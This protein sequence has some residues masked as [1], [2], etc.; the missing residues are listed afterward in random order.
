MFI[1]NMVEKSRS[2]LMSKHNQIIALRKKAKDTSLSKNERDVS[3]LMAEKLTAKYG[4]PKPN[5]DPK[6]K[7][8]KDNRPNYGRIDDDLPEGE[9]YK[10]DVPALSMY[11]PE[12][13]KLKRIFLAWDNTEYRTINGVICFQTKNKE[14]AKT[15]AIILRS[16]A[17]DVKHTRDKEEKRK[18]TVWY[19]T[20]KLFGLK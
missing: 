2:G 17:N 12:Y 19:K 18:E 16:Y 8:L 7:Y 10:V 13:P 3:R 6:P 14:L 9:A 5:K 4:E 1:G 11:H 20:K 15:V